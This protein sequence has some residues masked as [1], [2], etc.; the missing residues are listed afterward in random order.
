MTIKQDIIKIGRDRQSARIEIRK[1]QLRQI[2]DFRSRGWHEIADKMEK[3]LK[4]NQTFSN[5]EDGRFEKR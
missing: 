1:M 2:E 3:E 4:T 5:N